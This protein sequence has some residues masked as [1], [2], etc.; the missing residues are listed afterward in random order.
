M[1]VIG[2]NYEDERGKPLKLF[3]RFGREDK[4]IHVSRGENGTPFISRDE[5]TVALTTAKLRGLAGGYHV[6]KM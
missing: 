2:H 1:F 4:I 5:A 6:E 3:V